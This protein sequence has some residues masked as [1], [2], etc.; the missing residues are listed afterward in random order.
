MSIDDKITIGMSNYQTNI[1]LRM[2]KLLLEGSVQEIKETGETVKLKNIIQ[3]LEE[4]V[5]NSSEK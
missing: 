2:L 5:N 3:L 4:S 1:M